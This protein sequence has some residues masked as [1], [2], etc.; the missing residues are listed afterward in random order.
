MDL[1]LDLPFLHWLL[2]P[3][4]IIVEGENMTSF[5]LASRRASRP[6]DFLLFEQR[7]PGEKLTMVPTFVWPDGFLCLC[8]WGCA[9]YSYLDMTTGRVFRE[10]Y[11]GDERYGFE[12]E[13]LSLEAWFELWMAKGLDMFDV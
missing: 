9:I 2:Q 6:V 3:S 7:S 12:C 10:A 1:R 13:A 11:Y 8:H 5:Y 4:P